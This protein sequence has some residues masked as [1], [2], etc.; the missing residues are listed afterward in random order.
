[1]Y[2]RVGCIREVVVIL[3]VLHVYHIPVFRL[4][5]HGFRNQEMDE[6]AN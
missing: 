4:S 3:V 1:M 5:C 6:S 2:L